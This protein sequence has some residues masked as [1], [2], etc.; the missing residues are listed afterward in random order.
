[1]NR[2]GVILDA[3]ALEAL[4]GLPS[5]DPRGMLAVVS[6]LF[7]HDSPP[8]FDRVGDALSD[9]R[10]DLARSNAHALK[11]YAGT[12]G[13][14]SLRSALDALERACQM[15]DTTGALGCLALAREAY[16]DALS[17]LESRLD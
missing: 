17:A 8:L 5:P 10:M 6:E 7:R 2:S 1:M 11:S 3:A 12:V 14:V 4:R 15:G 13:A 9:G 16:G